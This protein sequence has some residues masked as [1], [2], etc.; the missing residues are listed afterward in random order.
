MPYK[1]IDASQMRVFP[2]AER[3]SYIRIE[4]KRA[5]PS[6]PVPDAGELKDPIAALAERIRRARRANT[7]VILT[8]GAHLIKNGAG[9]LV[10]A[11]IEKG[12]VTHIATHGAGI[13]HDWEFAFNGISSESVRDNAR[14]GRFGAWDETGR[15]INLAALCA[16]ADG[17]GLGEGIGRFIEEDGVTLPSPETLEEQIRQAPG[18]ALTAARADLLAA[19]RRFNLPAGRYAVAHPYKRYSVPACAY[20]NRVPMTVHLG[21]GYDIFVNHPMFH[22]GALGRASG[23][24]ARVLAASMLNLSGGV[25]LSVGSAIMSPQIFEKAFSAANGV[26]AQQGRPFISGH[27]IAIVDIQDGG[28]WDWTRGEP[29]ADNPAFYLRFCKS[30]HRLGDDVRYFCCDNRV[31]MANL[32]AE[33]LRA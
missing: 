12:F 25:Y 1:Q 7:A 30:F 33:L 29:P 13:I 20:R 16:A 14:A 2:L 6:D 8:Y 18:D 21:I 24:D 32:V 26:L 10:N 15:A 23:T 28:G 17:I 27:Q 19:M 31:F 4:Q 11:L 22:G 9:P 5:L 3:K